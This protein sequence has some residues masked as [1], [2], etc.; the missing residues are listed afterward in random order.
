MATRWRLD[1][2][3]LATNGVN[4]TARTFGKQ[5]L[6]PLDVDDFI[7]PFAGRVRALALA[8]GVCT[9]ERKPTT[10]RGASAAIQHGEVVTVNG[11]VKA[12]VPQRRLDVR[13]LLPGELSQLVGPVGRQAP[14]EDTSFG[15]GEIHRVAL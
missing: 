8:R 11:L 15:G 14:R 10:R 12:P 2:Q 6:H 9:F 3:R 1:L 13:R 4:E 7:V 5:G